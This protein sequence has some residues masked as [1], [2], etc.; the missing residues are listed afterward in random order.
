MKIEEVINLKN[1]ENLNNRENILSFFSYYFIFNFIYLEC[2]YIFPL[3]SS[4]N[5]SCGHP[6]GQAAPSQIH[7]LIFFSYYYHIYKQVNT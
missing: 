1:C 2:I 6:Q 7:G 4:T 5:P 3:P